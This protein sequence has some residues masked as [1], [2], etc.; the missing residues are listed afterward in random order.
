[1]PKT[2][3]KLK[4]NKT[5]KPLKLLGVLNRLVYNIKIC[6]KHVLKAKVQPKGYP[7]FK[8]MVIYTPYFKSGKN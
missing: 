3:S 2:C 8:N 5:K 6:L 4:V 1:M 7:E